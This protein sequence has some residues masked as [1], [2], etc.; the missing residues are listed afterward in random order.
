MQLPFVKIS[1]G[2][3]GLV[4]LVPVIRYSIPRHIVGH[5]IERPYSESEL[6]S[7]AD[8]VIQGVFQKGHPKLMSAKD[9]ETLMTEWTVAVKKVYRGAQVDSV[10]VSIPGGNI[11][12]LK[13]EQAGA[14]T[15]QPRSSAIMFLRWLPEQKTYVLVSQRSGYRPMNGAQVETVGR[16]EPLST[17]EARLMQ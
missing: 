6:M 3:V 1:L 15:V 14:A 2:I 16:V 9:D 12:A 13:V 11:G 7:D 10:Q 5:T 4:F 8:L 17:M